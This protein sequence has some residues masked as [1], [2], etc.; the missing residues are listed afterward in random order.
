MRHTV[1]GL[2][3]GLVLIFGTAGLLAA[4]RGAVPAPSGGI[5]AP[6]QGTPTATLTGVPPTVTPTST[7]PCTPIWNW[8]ASPNGGPGANS[9]SGVAALAPDDIWA[10]GSY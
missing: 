9:L 6:A 10:V 7:P 2:L 8:V 3:V 1:L 5:A 4:Q